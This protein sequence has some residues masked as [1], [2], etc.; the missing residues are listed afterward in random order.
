MT[1][2][3][4]LTAHTHAHTQTDTNA[5]H[6]SHQSF[7]P[8]LAVRQSDVLYID[9]VEGDFWCTVISFPLFVSLYSIFIVRRTYTNIRKCTC[10]YRCKHT[11]VVLVSQVLVNKESQAPWSL[12]TLI[13][14]V[15][16]LSSSTATQHCSCTTLSARKKQNKTQVVHLFSALSIITLV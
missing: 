14:V 5:H 8:K 15:H 2:L 12:A 16:M 11:F 9:W 3:I 1:C 6:R 7:A 4:L 10:T 13:P